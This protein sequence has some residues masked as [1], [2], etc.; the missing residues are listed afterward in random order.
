ME[1]LYRGL[2]PLIFDWG[3]AL[4]A[5]LDLDLRLNS[6]PSLTGVSGDDPLL[7]RFASFLSPGDLQRTVV[8]GGTGKRGVC[9]FS[10]GC[11]K[12][13]EQKEIIGQE[14]KRRGLISEGYGYKFTRV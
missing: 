5:N 7:A 12:S 1:G 10:F 9:K 13:D 3:L 2:S 4:P 8:M 11:L 14:Q 6:C